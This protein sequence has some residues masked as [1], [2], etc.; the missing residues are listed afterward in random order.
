MLQGKKIVLGVT[1][2]IAA[3]KAASLIRLLVK[4]GAEVRVILT[5][6]ASE[7]ITPLTLATLSKNPVLS[8]FH[9]GRTGEWNSHVELGLW[10][11]LM[12]VAPV[13]AKTLSQMA[14][15]HCDSL[16]VATYLSARCP[17]HFAPAMDL[18]MYQHP[19]TLRNIEAL[20]SYG[21]VFIDA[22]YGELASGLVGA[23]RMAEPEEIVEHVRNHFSEEQ[24]LAGKKAMIT[25][26]PTYE[27]IDPVRFI[28][29]HSSGKMGYA[30]A[31]ALLDRGAEVTLVSGPTHCHLTHPNLE[32]VPVVSA[33]EMLEACE[34]RFDDLD[35]AVMAAAVADYR[36]K[37]VA[38]QKIKKNSDEF[39]IECEKTEDIA[40]SLGKLKTTQFTVGFAL[41][42]E[43]EEDNAL[44]K[45]K[46]KNFDMIVLNSLNDKGAGFGH[47]TN[48]ITIIGKEG[49]KREFA[50]KSKDEV[51]HDIVNAIVEKLENGPLVV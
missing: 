42:T 1:G 38:E 19:S 27:A 18:D 40:K 10:A 20:K 46:R 44:G 37:E 8:D 12:L 29:N 34:E 22:G 5:T 28:G 2:S 4:E 33:K 26:G 47:D 51:A 31:Q 15:G 50:L 16:L 36:P 9:R 7:F 25:A 24:S 6:S 39:S 35:I 41:E 11:D 32:V 45:L 14:S 43:N 23:G 48:K 13:T 17:V 30:I 21:N 3:Y 49:D